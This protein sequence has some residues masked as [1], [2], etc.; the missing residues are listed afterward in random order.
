MSS[1]S[2]VW[3]QIHAD[4]ARSASVTRICRRG[5]S[6]RNKIAG[7]GLLAAAI[8][9]APLH[10]TARA[11]NGAADM[12]AAPSGTPLRTKSGYLACL[13]KQWLRDFV[14]RSVAGD[15]ATTNAY[16]ES[17]RCVRV[18]GGL[19]VTQSAASDH[20]GT[21]GFLFEGVEFWTVADAVER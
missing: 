9:A 15:S 12:A 16:I 21:V 2:G 4:G 1:G 8:S 5:G 11:E 13:Q 18:R 20:E 6:L 3:S 7:F 10:W 17:N 14:E 19:S